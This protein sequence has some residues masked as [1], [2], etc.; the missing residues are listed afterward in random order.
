[1]AQPTNLY[2]SYDAKGIREDLADVIFNVTPRDTPLLSSIRREEATATSHEWQ[3]D[4]LA[5]PSTTNAVIEGDESA[6]V[7]PAATTRVNNRTQILRKV[8]GVSTTLEKAKK[9]GRA[10]EVNYQTI[11]RG[12][13][14][15]RDIETMLIG[16]NAASVAGDA[17]TARIS[18]SLSS[19]IATNDTASVGASPQNRGTS[20]AAGGFSAGTGLTVAATDGTVRVFD[21]AMLDAV[22][23]KMWD[24]SGTVEDA[25]VHAGA[26]QKQKLTNFDGVA[27]TSFHEVKDK[28][29]Q[30]TM[31]V[32][33]SQF[34]DI[35]IVP[36]R[37][38]R[39]TSGTDREVYLLR[40][41]MLALAVFDP[42]HREELAK[43]GLSKKYHIFTEC[44]LQVDN[45]AGLAVVADLA[46]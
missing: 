5:A 3:I 2:D 34:G 8:F 14:L 22:I 43:T 1:M 32:Y 29:I 4:S 16:K 28:T 20:G 40:P 41:S 46:A 27:G 12:L 6:L 13:E 31:D 10:S 33:A 24:N 39:K 45:E 15:K 11:K 17:S 30:A 38:I 21:Q 35:R 25:V 23:A 44:T 18:G 36:N 19:W 26:V 42:I 9:A 37:Y 7:E